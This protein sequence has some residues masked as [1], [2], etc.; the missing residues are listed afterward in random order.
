MPYTRYSKQVQ[1]Y[2]LIFIS[3]QT[4]LRYSHLDAFFYTQKN[5]FAK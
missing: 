2:R 4:N 3:P 1:P 5:F